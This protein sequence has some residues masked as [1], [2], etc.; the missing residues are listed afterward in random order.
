MSDG[1]E[2]WR[3][4]VQWMIRCGVIDANHRVAEAD[5]LIGDFAS[6]LRDGVLLC[7]LCNRLCEDCIDVKNLQQRPQMAQFLCCKNI[8][9]FL[10]AC[11]HTFGMRP[12][13]IFDAWDLYRLDDFGKVLRTLSKLS[14]C[15]KAGLTGIEGFPAKS[16]I[17][18]Y[19]NDDAIYRNLREGAEDKEP[20]LE[21]VYDMGNAEEELTSGRIYD[22]I[23]CQRPNNQFESRIIEDDKWLSFKPETK[24]EHC[25]KELYDTENNYV[26]KALEMIISKFYTP[27]LDVLS[28]EDHKIIFMNILELLAIHHPFRDHLRQAVMYAAGLETPRCSETPLSI[29]DVF[30]TWKEKFVAYGKYC[31][32]LP[33]SR[34][35]ICELEKTDPVV[36][37]KIIECGQVANRNQFHLQDLL[38]IPMQRVL[39]YHVLLSEM[40]KL[41]SSDSPDRTS[42]EEAKEAM[43]DI[44][45]Y[46]NEMKRDYEMKQLVAAIEKSITGLEMP[47]GIHLIDYG[48]L[49]RDGE[50]KIANHGSKDGNR[51]KNRYIFVFDKVMIVCKSL[52][53][54]Q[55]SYK[56]AYLLRDYRVEVES[57]GNSR[58]GTLTKKLTANG[59]YSFSLVRNHADNVDNVLSLCCKTLLQRDAWV[60][61]FETAHEN[62]NPKAGELSGHTLQYNSY[63]RAT[64]CSHCRKLLAG[65]FFQGYHCIVCYRNYHRSCIALSKCGKHIQSAHRQSFPAQ[66]G[67][68]R[69]HSSTLTLQPYECLRAVRSFRSTDTKF[70]SF[71]KNDII[72]VIK[73]NADGT[74]VGRLV[75]VPESS[76]GI[77]KTEFI[78]RCRMSTSALTSSG[79]CQPVEETSL[80]STSTPTSPLRETDINGS[81]A[82]PR[83]TRSITSLASTPGDVSPT[84]FTSGDE[85]VNTDITGQ[86]WYQGALNRIE[87]EKRLSRTP[88]GTFLVR[89]SCSNGQSKFVVSISFNGDVKHTKV[90]R[91]ENSDG[92]KYYLDEGIMF[93]SIVELINYYSE[94]NLRESFETLNTTLRQPYMCSTFKVLH[95]FEATDPNYLQLNVGEQ[96]VVISRIGEDRGWWKG[97]IG[98]RIGYFPMTYVTPVENESL[99]N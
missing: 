45:S 40:I 24:R 17:N 43:Q 92:E 42:L 11:Q 31:S 3:E 95:S 29:G 81:V 44:N 51:M 33:D 79:S 8:C 58:L 13:D 78:R 14:T 62:D 65:L 30:K 87:A 9:E 99:C 2:L 75:S 5:A 19:Y 67:Y 48:R 76:I 22:T 25:I 56:G 36:R 15:P 88:D 63:D 6:I 4:C 72:E 21:N 54:N 83:H 69:R 20:I 52:R 59:G 97:R 89:H 16:L 41:T 61:N 66:S 91:V 68:R 60:Q 28:N 39:K 55:Y 37:Q 73:Q 26:E 85:Y 35:R 80:T 82:L 93:R 32:H 71:E 70:L 47:V 84:R 18:E 53:G 57:D 7:M 74:I 27:L 46:V 90:E 64:V 10:K 96:V 86:S 50:I 94:H 23:V 98:N 12:D 77:V 1:S 38:S 49:V 34:F